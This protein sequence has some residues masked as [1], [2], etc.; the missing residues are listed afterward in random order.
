M[1]TIYTMRHIRTNP[2]GRASFILLRHALSQGMDAKTRLC[3]TSI[4]WIKILLI[5]E[6]TVIYRRHPCSSSQ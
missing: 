6:E 5:N 4:G 3:R 1:A 2:R